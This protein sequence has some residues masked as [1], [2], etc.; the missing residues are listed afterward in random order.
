MASLKSIEGIGATYASKLK[1][2]G[3]T[4]TEEL[5]SVCQ[6]PKGRKDLGDKTGI[7]DALI[8]RWANHVDLFRIKGVGP[9]YA[10]LLEAAGVDTV[11]ELAQ[12]KAES[13]LEKMMAVNDAKKKVRRP[14]RLSQVQ[15]WVEQAKKLPRAI[16]Y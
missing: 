1:G 10:E 15:D 7:G 5:L 11:P 6:T 2:A 3:V 8:L 13:L 12:R 14:P 4:T 16:N 9:E